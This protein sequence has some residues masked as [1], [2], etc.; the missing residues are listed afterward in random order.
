MPS[1]GSGSSPTPSP[2]G[3][4]YLAILETDITRHQRRKRFLKSIGEN[5]SLNYLLYG[6]PGTGKTTLVR[7]LGSKLGFSIYIVNPNG[8]VESRLN[9][10]LNPKSGSQP[11]ILLFEDFDRFLEDP[12]P[13]KAALMSQILNSLDGLDGLDSKSNVSRFFTGNNCEIIFKNTALNNRMCSRFKFDLPPRRCIE[14][15]LTACSPSTPH[16]IPGARTRIA[17]AWIRLIRTSSSLP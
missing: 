1:T 3:R 5:K 14:E 17:R 4:R 10:V 7:T 15:S 8:I 16:P 11:I 9:D 12:S 13:G 2:R 6:L